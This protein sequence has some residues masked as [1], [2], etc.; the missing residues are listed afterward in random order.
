[1]KVR[2]KTF[3]VTGA[4]GGIGG[5]ITKELIHRGAEVIGVDLSLAGLK[6]TQSKLG[7]DAP[8]FTP[9]TLNITDKKAIEKLPAW[10]AEQ[11]RVVDGVINCAGII[12]PFERVNDLKYEDIERVMNI[13]FYGTLY[14]T[15][16]FLPDLLKRPEAYVANIS[17]MGGFLPVPGQSVYGASKAA[18]KLLTEA[19]YA[20]L[21][22][23]PVHVSI[24][25]PG[26]TNTNIAQNSRVKAP[27]VSDEQTAKLQA[28]T[29][30]PNAA[31]RIVV[32][33]IEK[34]QTYI[35]TGKDSRFM[36]KLYRLNPRYATRFIA[37]Q[38][39]SLLG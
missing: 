2:S 27:S 18:V 10:L 35:Y 21:I 6:G 8:A 37:R 38:M 39:K 7:D 5:A 17:S 31:A 32:N 36:N 13:N 12:Q 3:L 30:S 15:K 25:F 29:L 33:G 20:E 28:S 24:I 16:T 11:G 23:T 19:L 22:D 26:A 1:M 9:K 14:I 34:N 4:G